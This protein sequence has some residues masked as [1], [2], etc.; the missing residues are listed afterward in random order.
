MSAFG[1]FRVLSYLATT[2]NS[3]SDEPYA[4]SSSINDCPGIGATHLMG[5]MRI[6]KARPPMASARYCNDKTKETR[7]A[8]LEGVPIA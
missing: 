1:K 2:P 7:D 3:S 5:K 4:K 6:N 8:S